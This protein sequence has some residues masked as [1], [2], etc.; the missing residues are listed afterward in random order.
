VQL[1]HFGRS[2][3]E[4]ENFKDPIISDSDEDDDAGTI[5]GKMWYSFGVQQ[6]RVVPFDKDS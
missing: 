4:V 2:L 6:C 1:T 3:S 5:S